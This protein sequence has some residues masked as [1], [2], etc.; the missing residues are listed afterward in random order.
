MPN[1]EMIEEAIDQTTKAIKII[2]PNRH[3]GIIA[4]DFGFVYPKDE[5]RRHIK[6]LRK[7]REILK[8]VR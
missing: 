2:W 7:Y 3:K 1:I 6:I 4:W 5:I 8:V